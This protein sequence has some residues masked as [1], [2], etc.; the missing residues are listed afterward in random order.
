M[1]AVIHTGVPAPWAAPVNRVPWALLPLG[2]RPLLEY[3]LEWCSD[4]HILDIRLVLDDGAKQIEEYVGSGESWGLQVTYGFHR[5]QNDPVHFLKRFSS[6]DLLQGLMHVTGPAFPR[7]TG[8]QSRHPESGKTLAYINEG[9]ALCVLSRDPAFLEAWIKGQTDLSTHQP[10]QFES[11][12]REIVPLESLKDLYEINMSLVQGEVQNYLQPGY[13]DKD[14]VIIG[15]NVITPPTATLSA[16]LIIGNDC[17]ISPMTSIGPNAVVGSHVLIDRQSEIS[18]SV[19]LSGT[20]IGQG[21][22]IRSK[23][24]FGNTVIDPYS[25]AVVTIPDPWMVSEVQS[26]PAFRDILESLF[27]RM[28]AGVIALT[29]LL[30]FAL[31][32][33]WKLVQGSRF[34]HKEVQGRNGRVLKL[35]LYTQAKVSHGIS[36][37]I[38]MA[39][40][41]DRYP[42]FLLAFYGR[43]WL[44]GH[45]PRT[46]QSQA[47]QDMN[48]PDAGAF[49]AA[50]TYADLREQDNDADLER[51]EDLYYR[52][53]RS[54]WEDMRML[55][56]FI[57]KRWSDF[58]R[59]RN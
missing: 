30:P 8:M 11:L 52:H 12:G 14:N 57:I 26:L 37:R 21:M 42:H 25:Q 36:D 38:F 45:R 27:S 4:M 41:L 9:R 17:R 47:A 19:I 13:Y 33:G 44:C 58:F 22:E 28:A 56:H 46:V 16:P 3:W 7:K 10:D 54:L 24:V 39:L 40:G 5:N 48:E 18:D 49:P 35:P 53:H 29:Q 15:Y 31:L 20:F 2:N 59:G 23:I 51:V 6:D 43:L 1:K 50:I 55:G 34:T 32:F